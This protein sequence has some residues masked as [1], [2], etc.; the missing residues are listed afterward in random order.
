MPRPC[1][2]TLF[3][4]NGR[5]LVSRAMRS[6]YP[7]RD[8]APLPDTH[9]TRNDKRPLIAWPD[10]GLMNAGRALVF[11]ELALHIVFSFLRLQ[12]ERDPLYPQS[13]SELLQIDDQAIERDWNT[14]GEVT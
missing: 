14:W 9:A 13:L 3:V 12:K 8:H 10:G 7:G 11:G 5:R 1:D 6:G 2:K 4:I